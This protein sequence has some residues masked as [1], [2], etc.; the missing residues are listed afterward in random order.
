MSWGHQSHH[1]PSLGSCV[2]PGTA[3]SHMACSS[4]SISSWGSCG[5]CLA[6]PWVPVTIC[7]PPHWISERSPSKIV[8]LVS[9]VIKAY[10]A[11]HS[12][13]AKIVFQNCQRSILMWHLDVGNVWYPEIHKG[14]DTADSR[15][16]GDPVPE[17]HIAPRPGL[18]SRGN[19]SPQQHQNP[20]GR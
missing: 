20:G 17:D 3:R 14:Q 2:C 18:A 13:K 4:G 10:G 7:S 9:H 12:Q 16:R 19:N 15:T 6:M 5:L 8:P 11:N 1:P